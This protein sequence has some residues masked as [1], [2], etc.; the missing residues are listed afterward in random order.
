MGTWSCKF[1]YMVRN[2]LIL[3]ILLTLTIWS[4]AQD[5]CNIYLRDTLIYKV[6]LKGDTAFWQ[7]VKTLNIESIVYDKDNSNQNRWVFESWTVE[8]GLRKS[9]FRYELKKGLIAD[10][11]CHGIKVDGNRCTRP[12]KVGVLFC[13]QHD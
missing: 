3:A 12:V 10:G 9:A 8:N 6:A 1:D 11:I 13:W 5:T 2:Y 7:N 4:Q